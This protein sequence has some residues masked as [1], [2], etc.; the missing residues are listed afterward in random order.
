MYLLINRHQAYYPAYKLQLEMALGAKELTWGLLSCTKVPS[1]QELNP[2]VGIRLAVEPICDADSPEALIAATQACRLESAPFVIEYSR[3]KKLAKRWPSRR[4]MGKLA[5][6]INGD[7]SYDQPQVRF[8]LIESA[9][10]YYLTR[11]VHI[12]TWS[13]P[14]YAQRPNAYSAAIS[15]ELAALAINAVS[16]VGDSI[17]DPT[18]GSGT[19]VYEALQRGRRAKGYDHKWSW[20]IGARENLE[21]FGY[22]SIPDKKRF[23]AHG[24][25]RELYDSAQVVIANLP[26]GRVIDIDMSRLESILKR[27]KDCAQSFAFFSGQD[28]SQVLAKLNYTEIKSLNLTIQASHQRYLC[29]AQG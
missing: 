22:S 5:L 24:D 15:S 16:Q 17:I 4:L 6:Q 26:Y 3:I 25:A 14:S 21:A 19:I 18:C 1:L 9:E 20:V 13:K 8:Q 29:F 23:I 28:L 12:P 7:I 10:R 27:L 11:L 2:L